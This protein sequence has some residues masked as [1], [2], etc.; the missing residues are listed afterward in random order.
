V[1]LRVLSHRRNQESHTPQFL[2]CLVILC[3]ERWCPKQNTDARFKSKDLSTRKFCAGYATVLSPMR[4]GSLFGRHKRTKECCIKKCCSFHSNGTTF[5]LGGNNI[6][7]QDLETTAEISSKVKRMREID[8]KQ[9]NI[10][11]CVSCRM[12]F[13]K[14]CERSSVAVAHTFFLTRLLRM[15]KIKAWLDYKFLSNWML[16]CDYLYLINTSCSA[17]C[18]ANK[19]GVGTHPN[20]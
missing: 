2:A 1:S 19:K 7:L 12:Q 15:L 9:R 8:K 20:N 10:V 6:I 17:G 5:N 11:C 18:S 13:A 4:K 14:S 16:K 3:V